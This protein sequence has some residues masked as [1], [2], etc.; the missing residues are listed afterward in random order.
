M[1]ESLP[2]RANALIGVHEFGQMDE[3]V[4]RCDGIAWSWAWRRSGTPLTH[5]LYSPK[6]VLARGDSDEVICLTGAGLRDLPPGAGRIGQR[7]TLPPG[8]G[9]SPKPACAGLDL[10][11]HYVRLQDCGE[12]FPCIPE[13]IAE[14]LS[15]R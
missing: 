15:R 1:F 8:L 12:E 2:R 7:H 5:G 4:E 13:A 14:K 3:L 11:D 6:R 10:V 9:R